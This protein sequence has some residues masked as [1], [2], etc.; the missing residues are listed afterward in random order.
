MNYKLYVLLLTLTLTVSPALQAM[1]RALVPI[2]R[3]LHE[4]STYQAGRQAIARTYAT[5][6]NEQGYRQEKPHYAHSTNYLPVTAITIG[7]GLTA[8]HALEEQDDSLAINKLD[9]YNMDAVL[10]VFKNGTEDEKRVL[11]ERIGQKITHYEIEDVITILR[12]TT[13]IPHR[14]LVNAISKNITSYTVPEISKILKWDTQDET[15]E[16]IAHALGNNYNYLT[17]DIGRYDIP[18]VQNLQMKYHYILLP[19]ILKNIDKENINEYYCG[20]LSQILQ[21]SKLVNDNT[22]A[23]VIAQNIEKFTAWDLSIY[24]KAS[25][26]HTLATAI[27]ADIA[28]NTN[29]QKYKIWELCRFLEAS[30]GRTTTTITKYI[31]QNAQKYTVEELCMFLKASND[32]V[33]ATTITR[34]IMQNVQKYTVEELCKYLEA[35][36]EPTLVTTITSYIMQNVPKYTLEEL[37]M[38]LGA[39]N[40]RT[41]TRHIAQ[42]IQKYNSQDLQMFVS[43]SSDQNRKIILEEMLAKIET[44]IGEYPI[45]NQSSAHLRKNPIAAWDY[46][47]TIAN[48]PKYKATIDQALIHEHQVSDRMASFYHSQRSPVYW[49]ELLY[50]KLWEQKYNQ[51]SNNYLFTRFPNDR[52]DHSNALLQFDGHKKR[53]DLLENGRTDELRPYL[54]FANYALFGNSTNWG[55]CSIHYFINNFN[56]G[57]PNITTATIIGTFGDGSL[58][59]KYRTELEQLET[60]FRKIVPGSVLL[61]IN[62]PHQTL[63]EHI[64]LAKP[65]G[66]KKKLCISG[67]E[68]DDVNTIIKTLKTN[69]QALEETDPHEFCLIMTPDTIHTLREHGTEIRIYGDFDQEKLKTLTDKLES[70]IARMAK[71]NPRTFAAKFTPTQSYQRACNKEESNMPPL[72]HILD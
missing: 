71:E 45:D 33:L 9:I 50:T 41:L 68:T 20:D 5:H 35:S 1:K 24:L 12:S 46:I 22:V 42:N 2:A 49:L 3:S 7:L 57:D 69:P 31:L 38:F 30:H 16:L 44:F 72:L 21:V 47:K 29:T 39:S 62:I 66:Y 61:Q 8:Q 48:N 40:D 6:N 54:F 60:E 65:F 58:F 18:F 59:G 55:S 32:N 28:K 27:A 25:N 4:P 26:D 67:E 13:H 56:I 15:H 51:K 36:H 52:T 17:R 23:V 53:A 70:L 14:N 63:N 19:H 10:E 43:A 11:A 37:C 64:Y 34:H